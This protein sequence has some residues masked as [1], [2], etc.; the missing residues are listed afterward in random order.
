[1]AAFMRLQRRAFFGEP[2][3]AYATA[4]KVPVSMKVSIA[5]MDTRC[6]R[7]PGMPAA[8]VSLTAVHLAPPKRCRLPDDMEATPMVL[9]KRQQIP[10]PGG[11]PRIKISGRVLPNTSVSAVL[12]PRSARPNPW[13]EGVSPACSSGSPVAREHHPYALQDPGSA[14]ERAWARRLSRQSCPIQPDMSDIPDRLWRIAGRITSA[15]SGV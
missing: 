8:P 15:M 4:Q 1:M 9:P 3:E 2:K 5:D 7:P 13:L 10:T 14:R 11:D 12:T 6:R